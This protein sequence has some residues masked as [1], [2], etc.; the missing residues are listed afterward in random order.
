VGVLGSRDRRLESDAPGTPGTTFLQLTIPLNPG[1]SG[2]PI[3][4][5]GGRVVGVLTGTHAQ[6]QAIAF[7][8]PV[9]DLLATL[10]ALEGGARVT[11]AF[12]GARTQPAVE[13][14]LV[15][16]VVLSGPADAAGLRKGDVIRAIGG[17]PVRTPDS[18]QAALDELPI[19]SVARIDVLRG[20]EEIALS[21][22]LTDRAEHPVVIAGMTL[23]AEPGIGGIV[24]A[25][26]PRSRA[27]VAGI[28]VGDLVRTVDGV[29][30]HAPAD[31]QDLLPGGKA[32][33]IEILRDGTPL[34]LTIE[35]S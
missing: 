12:L 17:N 26:R 35:G 11:R 22:E 6:G 31:V 23:R 33:Q 7:A 13:G 27:E 14:L 28:A 2:G 30:V 3:F 24:V 8:V 34:S 15:T 29:P 20:G 5:Q 18:L 25:V 16:S 19:Q 32:A 9:E 1:N 4:D 10:P 21:V